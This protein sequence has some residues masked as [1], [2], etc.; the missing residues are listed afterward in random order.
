METDSA[1]EMERRL[2]LAPW[3][4]NPQAIRAVFFDAGYTLIRPNPSMY[5]VV[6]RAAQREG[7]S[8]TE[9]ELRP[10]RAPMEQKYFGRHHVSL[11][12]WA[13][14]KAITSV[15]T[16]FFTEY[17]EGLVPD[18]DRERVVSAVLNEIAH[19]GAW[20]PYEDVMPAFEA[21]RGHYTMGVISDWGVGLGPILRE[22]GLS[23]YLDFL[24][25]S[26]TSRRAKPDPHL[27]ETALQR[28]NALGDY[29][30]YVGDTYVQ[31]ILG[32]R[33]AGIHPVLIDRRQRYNPA[34]LDCLVIH[35]LSDLTNLLHGAG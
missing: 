11:G 25:V 33:A 21:M 34:L 5:D 2:Q 15:W 22:L 8:L 6:S 13:D 10:R 4:R 1:L 26:A 23:A 30:L 12:T 18:T 31:D 28:A 9:A 29:A 27:F 24:I 35:S 32:A 7:F 16:A 3:L 20:Q 19:H 14:D 17:L